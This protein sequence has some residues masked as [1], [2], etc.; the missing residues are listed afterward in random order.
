MLC[1]DDLRM[2]EKGKR[3]KNIRTTKGICFWGMKVK[4]TF[5]DCASDNVLCRV[6]LALSDFV[7][8]YST[9]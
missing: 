2:A 7:V 9:G 6:N 4:K 3:N 5:S 8:N 1:T